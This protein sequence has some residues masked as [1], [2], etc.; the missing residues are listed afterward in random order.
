MQIYL[1][2]GFNNM[3]SHDKIIA[4]V[5]SDSAS[6]R[7]KINLAK[8]NDTLID[9]TQGRKTRSAIICE[10]NII[11]LSTLQPETIINRINN[12]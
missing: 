4:I 5:N 9:A 8:T 11:I 2:I 7:R 12:V 10:N 1:N 3:V 6:I